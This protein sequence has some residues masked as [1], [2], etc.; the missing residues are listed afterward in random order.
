MRN[1][2]GYTFSCGEQ[3]FEIIAISK[4]PLKQVGPDYYR[5]I[6]Y[7]KQEYDFELKLLELPVF[8]CKGPESHPN[9]DIFNEGDLQMFLFVGG[10][11]LPPEICII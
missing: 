9:L 11:L 8:L 3:I 4:V 1:Y 7:F 2:I 6:D 10:I 5:F